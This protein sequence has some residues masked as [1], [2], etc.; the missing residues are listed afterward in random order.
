MLCNAH[1]VAVDRREMVVTFLSIVF[2][3][4]AEGEI[5]IAG[6]VPAVTWRL[7]Y[8]LRKQNFKLKLL[9]ATADRSA[10]GDDCPKWRLFITG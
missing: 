3:E 2:L 4:A 10:Y 8:V 6:L 1:N 5:C 7:L 9:G